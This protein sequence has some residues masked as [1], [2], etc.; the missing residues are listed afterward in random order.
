MKKNDAALAELLML[1]RQPDYLKASAVAFAKEQQL[2]QD[3]E[4]IYNMDWLQSSYARV[5][6][7]VPVKSQ[8]GNKR[9][10]LPL[11]QGIR[12]FK[13]K[14]FSGQWPLHHSQ[15]WLSSKFGPRRKHDGTL[16]YHYGID[17]AALTGTPVYA[18]A[19][20][21][22]EQA[23]YSRTGYGNMIVMVHNKKYSTRYAHLD[24]I[25][26]KKGQKVKKGSMIGRVGATG[27]VRGKNASHLHFEVQVF[28]KR[29]NPLY[30]LI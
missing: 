1:N 10:I 23:T 17:M 20:G 21:I 18:I 5:P 7:G 26:V 19:D 2:E 14:D 3:V 30:I 15:F 11:Q 8:E 4:A 27:S 13:I 28:G 22:I 9:R 24:V 6:L 16:G 25:Y 12:S 29:I